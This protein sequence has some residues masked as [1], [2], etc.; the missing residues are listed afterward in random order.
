[1]LLQHLQDSKAA[2]I[3]YTH[4]LQHRAGKHT[5]P[6]HE[7]NKESTGSTVDSKRVRHVPAALASHGP[8][9]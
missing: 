3:A 7:V 8:R 5:A 9:A 1:M 6:H 4:A 2:G